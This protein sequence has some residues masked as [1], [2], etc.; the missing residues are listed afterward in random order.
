MIM[1]FTFIFMIINELLKK[2]S[3]QI[4][5]KFN[6]NFWGNT[7]LQGPGADWALNIQLHTFTITAYVCFLSPGSDN[8]YQEAHRIVWV[9][10]SGKSREQ[11]PKKIRSG[12]L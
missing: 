12:L 10:L 2:S 3:F 5:H 1:Y 4:F 9:S 7:T 11:T 6:E 8:F